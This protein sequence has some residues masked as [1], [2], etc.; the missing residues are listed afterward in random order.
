MRKAFKLLGVAL[1]AAFTFA[2]TAEAAAPPKKIVHKRPKHSTRVSA[3]G[4]TAAKKSTTPKGTS[5]AVKS[6][7]K[8]VKRTPTTKPR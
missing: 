5:G 7:K 3:G 1:L 2:A 6:T 4:A 8:A